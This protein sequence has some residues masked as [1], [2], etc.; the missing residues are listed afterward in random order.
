VDS[1][2]HEDLAR[3]SI[4][5]LDE[6]FLRLSAV[7]DETGVITDFQYEYGNRA[8][9]NV[10]RR[11]RD[12]LLGQRLLVLF[13]SHRTNGLFDAYVRVTETAEPRRSEFHFDDNGVVGEFEVLACRFGDGLILVGH[14]ISDR[15]DEER[16]LTSLASQLQGALTSRI[17]IEQAKGYLAARSDTNPEA[18]FAAIRR[19]ARDHNQRISEVAQR[20]VGGEIDLREAVKAPTSE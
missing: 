17:V 13:P 15:K 9:L 8:A 6:A 3:S 5:A 10:L 19:Y 12:E 16:R 14:D 1:S 7:R 20:V 11:R 18:A 4:E 2:A